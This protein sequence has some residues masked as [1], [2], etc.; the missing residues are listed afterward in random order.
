MMDV[1]S[2]SPIQELHSVVVDLFNSITDNFGS[3]YLHYAA[4]PWI[5]LLWTE[6]DNLG[7]ILQQ[8]QRHGLGGHHFSGVEGDDVLRAIS[9]AIDTIK[10]LQSV[11]QSFLSGRMNH[12][13]FLKVEEAICDRYFTALQSCRIYLTNELHRLQKYG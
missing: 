12:T 13:D 2:A 6:I 4:P 10:E 5:Q 8:A 9:V 3:Q 1:Q 7:S 11:I